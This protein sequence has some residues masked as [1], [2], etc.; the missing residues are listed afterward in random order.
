MLLCALR[1]TA[2]GDSCTGGNAALQQAY[3][4]RDWNEAVRVGSALAGRTAD[5]NFRLGMALARLQRWPE[6]HDALSAGGRQCP[7]DER[8]DVELAGVAFQQKKY[9]NAAR[10]LRGALKLKPGDAYAQNFAGTVNY[11]W[12]NLPAAIQHWNR[13]E[14]PFLNAIEFDP[15][16]RTRRLLLDRSFAFAPQQLLHLPE[17]ETT[18]ARLNALGIFSTYNMALAQRRD[19]RFDAQFHGMERNGFGPGRVPALISV[20]S[21][22]PYETVYPSYWNMGRRAM[23]LNALLRWD[24][25]KRRAWADVSAP[26]HEL[27]QFRWNADLDLRA[28]NWDVRRWYGAAP[29][30]GSLHL[31]KAAATAIFADIHSGSLQWKIG[32]E[33]SGRRFTQVV[34]GTAIPAKLT[35]NGVEAAFLGQADGTLLRMPERRFTIAAQAGARL[36]RLWSSPARMFSSVDGGTMLE[37]MPGSETGLWRLVQRVRAGKTFGTPPFDE[38]YELGMERD[39][40]LWLRGVVATRGRRN[41]SGLLGT[42]YL[43]ANSDL[44]RRVYS[45]GLV[46]I[47]MGPLFDFGRMAGPTAELSPRDW[48]ASSGAEVRATVLGTTVVFTYGRDLR[49]GSNAFYATTAH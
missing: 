11:L 4:R 7:R 34:A 2:Q 1:G 36:A 23:N 24:A 44:T 38:L 26:V 19:G 5:D 14:K 9:A 46:S 35:E 21:G 12:G 42:A 48:L 8:F 49:N 27:P 20:L 45:N 29:S 39:N 28:E 10:W 13:V 6:A 47:G 3:A 15:N 25:E 37:W 17:Y 33:L 18:E 41:G 22:V 32:G 30:L 40:D 16:L 31:R 43:L